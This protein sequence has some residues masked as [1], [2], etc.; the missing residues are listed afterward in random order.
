MRYIPDGQLFGSRR[1]ALQ[2]APERRDERS[3]E[4]GKRSEKKE[5]HQHV[6]LRD[7]DL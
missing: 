2:D 1:E 7:N 5:E 4:V 3:V 6:V